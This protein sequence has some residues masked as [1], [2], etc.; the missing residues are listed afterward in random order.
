MNEVEI[1]RQRVNTVK[2]AEI[3]GVTERTIYNW[4]RQQRIES[5]RTDSGQVRI[6]V[7]TLLFSDRRYT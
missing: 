3:A 7:D 6:F 1:E 5:L 4:I 2:A